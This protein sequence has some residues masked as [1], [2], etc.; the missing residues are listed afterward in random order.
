MPNNGELKP[1]PHSKEAEEA[2]LGGII[3]E[4]TAAFERVVPW[5]REDKAF[6]LKDNKIIW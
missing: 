3:M 4:G 5:I 2:I 6:Y 1:S